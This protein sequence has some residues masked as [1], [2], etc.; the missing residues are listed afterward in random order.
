[1]TRFAVRSLTVVGTVTSSNYPYTGSFGSTTLGSGMIDQYLYVSDASLAEDAPYTE[2]YLT[3]DGALGE[4]SE[5]DD[6]QEVVDTTKA[7]LEALA[8]SGRK[9]GREGHSYLASL[10][11][12]DVPNR[13]SRLPRAERRA[14]WE[15]WRST[16]GSGCVRALPRFDRVRRLL[17]RCSFSMS[18]SLAVA[19]LFRKAGVT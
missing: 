2:L 12:S 18:L 15:H 6:Y 11:L 7:R 17:R 16:L 9:V 8:A 1:M 4:L 14:A 19:R 13:L 10:W 3:V 5:S